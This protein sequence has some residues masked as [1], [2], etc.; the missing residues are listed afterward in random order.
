MR[1]L[2]V[3]RAYDRSEVER[4]LAAVEDEAAELERRL[5]AAQA[6]R[7]R[8]QHRVIAASYQAGREASA[9]GD[10]REA[11]S[12]L[13]RVEEAHAATLADIRAASIADARR[14]LTSAEREVF[15]LRAALQGV[16][17]ELE[18]GHL[19]DPAS[20]TPLAWPPTTPPRTVTTTAR[21][22]HP[23]GGTVSQLRA[24]DADRPPRLQSVV[25]GP[26]L[27]G[28]GALRA[29]T[30]R[31]SGTSSPST[32]RRLSWR[33]C[34]PCSTSSVTMSTPRMR[35]RPHGGRGALGIKPPAPW[36]APP[37]SVIALSRQIVEDMAEARRVQ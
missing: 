25:A 3:L 24:V 28:L 12:E 1:S 18:T 17:D 23:R 14:L 4:Y 10:V 16:L 37:P 19:D 34:A 5:D 21:R 33:R 32:S 27:A 26:S 31:V 13:Q 8:A 9:S 35:R 7:S 29:A 6:R 11:L 2:P 22:D 30:S 15:V 36:S 20:P